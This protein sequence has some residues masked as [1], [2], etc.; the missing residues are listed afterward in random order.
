V[1]GGGEVIWIVIKEPDA[2]VTVLTKKT[3]YTTSR[4]AV[5]NVQPLRIASTNEAPSLL[6]VIQSIVLIQGD[7]VL[8]LQ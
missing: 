2:R 4:M 8:V 1:D 5:V 7:S 6:S 3:P